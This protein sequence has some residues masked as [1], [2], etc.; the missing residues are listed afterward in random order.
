MTN[1]AKVADI[2][3]RTETGQT[4]QQA[5]PRRA[6][7]THQDYWKSKLKRRSYRDRHGSLVEIPEWQ[8]RMFHQNREAWF[9]LETANQSAAALKARDIFLCIVSSGWEPALDRFKP[10]SSTPDQVAT[11]G[12]FLKDVKARSHLQPR[13]LR[14]YATKF[15]KL[16]SDVARVEKGQKRA[17][18]RQKFD[19]VNGGRAEWLTKV[20]GQRLDVL[21]SE[22]I[23]SWR[24]R[25]TAKA[26]HDPLRRKSAERTAASVI[27]TARALFAPDIVRVL[28][29]KLPPNPF[30]GVKLQ[31]PGPQRYHSEINP[32][33][34]LTCAERELREAKPQLYLAL[35]LCLWAGLRRR[36]ADL[37]TWQQIDLADG[38]LHVRR[39]QHFEPKT[40]ESQRVV[41]LSS[42]AVSILRAFKK[43]VRT[44]FVLDGLQPNSKATYVYYR[45]NATWQA[46]NKWLKEKGVRQR[47]AVHTLRKESGSLIASDFG[48][49]AARQHLGHRDI[50]TTSAHYVGK[51]KRIEVSIR[52]PASLAVAQ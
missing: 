47:M 15:R 6:A 49:E 25:Y 12:E 48:I 46:L 36:E 7:K 43:D 1:K 31:D 13:T 42:D 18:R 19:Y 30:E 14:I 39:T 27:R 52:Q 40:E 28:K 3:H 5:E 8:V 9:N 44:E 37:L 41:D 50:R 21:N 51:K 26:G 11:V 34:L 17:E 29:V 32:E 24:N 20:D 2:T 38:Q 4:T 35:F 16:V 45:C 33:W 22:S 10:R 23:T